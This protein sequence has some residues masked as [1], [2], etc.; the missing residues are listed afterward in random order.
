MKQVTKALNVRISETQMGML[1]KLSDV[2]MKSKADL[3]REAIEL[4]FKPKGTK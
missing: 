2:S 3:I 4:L 1:Q